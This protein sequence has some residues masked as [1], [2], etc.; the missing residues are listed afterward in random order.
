MN[1]LLC[2]LIVI[3]IVPIVVFDDSITFLL[4]TAMTVSTLDEPSPIHISS[5]P[6]LFHYY[7][8]ILL[9]HTLPVIKFIKFN[10]SLLPLFHSASTPRCRDTAIRSNQNNPGQFPAINLL[11]STVAIII[12]LVLCVFFTAQRVRLLLDIP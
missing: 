10:K 12:I 4:T 6:D 9:H 8:C 11:H 5:Y 3:V 2:L 7:L 1:T